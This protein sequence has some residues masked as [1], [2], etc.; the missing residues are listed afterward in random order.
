MADFDDPENN[1][2]FD[3]APYI[4]AIE[5]AEGDNIG[6]IIVQTKDWFEFSNGRVIVNKKG[7]ETGERI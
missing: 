6:E 7:E 5:K 3:E 4:S 1:G 2:Y